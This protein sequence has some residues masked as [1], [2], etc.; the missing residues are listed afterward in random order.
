MYRLVF[1][2]TI[3]TPEAANGWDA[4]KTLL[5]PGGGTG[6]PDS[7]GITRAE[8][9]STAI[10][11]ATER[12]N[13]NSGVSRL[14][15]LRYDTA[16]T[17]TELVATHEWNLNGDLPVVGP[18]LGLEAITWVPDSYLVANSFFDEGANHPYNPAEYPD[19]GTGLFFVGVEASGIVYAYALDHVT[20]AFHRI[21]TIASGNPGVMS[22]Y[23][24]RDVGYLW[25]YCDDTCG[26]VAGVMSVDT[27]ASSATFGK[28]KLLKQL[29]RPSTMPNINNEGIAVAPES[30]C[31]AG[32]KGFY[33]TDDSETG[34]HS[35]RFDKIPCGRFIP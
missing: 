35:I 12:D 3:W 6:A 17:G 29:A 20:G 21:A 9:S 34:G 5:Y 30:E 25:A 18:N 32:F 33:W 7:E 24:D 2:G 27:A 26:N 22:V 10:Y 1:N 15:I 4:G 19:H 13:N 28:F 14:S 8:L 11:V 16:G 31:A 23:F